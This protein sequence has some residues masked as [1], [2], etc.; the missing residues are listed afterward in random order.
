MTFT[1]LASDPTRGLLAA[2]TA[3]RSLAVGAGVPALRVGVGAAASQ[4]YTNRSLRGLLLDAVA[5]GASPA[6]AIARIPDWDSGAAWRQAAVVTAD[7]A[8]SAHTGDACTAWA[9]SETGEGFVV[10]GNLLPGRGV[11]AAMV[12]AFEGAPDDDGVASER[13]LAGFSRRVLAA[14]AAGDAAGGDLRGRQ[15][16]ALLVGVA[17]T[18]VDPAEVDL[19]PSDPTTPLGVTAAG[20]APLAID[21]RADDHARPIDELA[22][23]LDL[24]FDERRAA[25]R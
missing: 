21:L 25:E 19:L 4:A 9:G 18:A 10:L 1:I 16:A 5:S 12:A 11:L 17:P 13:A 24:A 20:D 7:G 14:L 2:A 3:S 23:L 8:V 22:R 15:S 6:T